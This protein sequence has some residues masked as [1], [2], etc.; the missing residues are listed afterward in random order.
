MVFY[1]ICTEYNPSN[2]NNKVTFPSRRKSIMFFKYSKTNY[3]YNGRN[4]Q[5]AVGEFRNASKT[6]TESYYIS[7]VL[8]KSNYTSKYKKELEAQGADYIEDHDANGNLL[9]AWIDMV[10]GCIQSHIVCSSLY[11]CLQLSLFHHYSI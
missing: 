9:D 7:Q 4:V 11:D 3:D 1:V 2:R 6:Q 5:S 8:F 10:K